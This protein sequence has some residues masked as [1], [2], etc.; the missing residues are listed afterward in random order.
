MTN[1]NGSFFTRVI[2]KNVEKVKPFLFQL[3]NKKGVQAGLKS[4][5]SARQ[6]RQYR[7]ESEMMKEGYRW[8]LLRRNFN[9]ANKKTVYFLLSNLCGI[10][11]KTTPSLF[12]NFA[13]AKGFVRKL[14]TL[15]NK[16]TLQN[17]RGENTQ[18][19]ELSIFQAAFLLRDAFMSLSDR[20]DLFDMPTRF[21]VKRDGKRSRSP[22][23][24]DYV[25]DRG[26]ADISIAPKYRDALDFI[27]MY[28][29]KIDLNIL[30]LSFI[31]HIE[32]VFISYDGS[33]ETSEK[34]FVSVILSFVKDI[35]RG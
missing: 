14:I 10:P 15:Q 2:Q 30:D 35:K 27:S 25:W 19:Y 32:E 1:K 31:E 22:I 21:A 26:F 4:I 17:K 23:A 11:Q 29:D 18:R 3:F 9:K 24:G 8:Y 16:K 34:P 13:E 33:Y 20:N 7:Q 5:V 12:K 28:A 6:I